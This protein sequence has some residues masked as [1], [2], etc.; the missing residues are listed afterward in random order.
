MVFDIIVVNFFFTRIVVI[1][2]FFVF[3]LFVSH[4][5]ACFSIISF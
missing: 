1:F 4:V 3:F 5:G 2:V